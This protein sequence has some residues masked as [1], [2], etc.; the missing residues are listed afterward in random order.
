MAHYLRKKD[1]PYVFGATEALMKRN[2]MY[3]CDIK[4]N[5]LSGTPVGGFQPSSIEEIAPTITMPSTMDKDELEVYALDKFKIDLDKR[6]SLPILRIQVEGLISG[7]LS[8]EDVKEG[9][10][11]PVVKED[12]P[13][14]EDE[15]IPEDEEVVVEKPAGE[16]D[17]K[18]VVPEV[19]ADITIPKMKKF[20][21]DYNLE[22][23]TK[24]GEKKVDV[25]KRLE[26]LVVEANKE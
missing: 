12:P 24:V 8:I 15:D 14:V 19:P 22:F 2:D 26:D 7:D 10:F 3:E 1:D 9:L 11:E 18:T 21:K 23:A 25:R 20:A 13:V 17:T 5:F 6:R 4:G 16:F